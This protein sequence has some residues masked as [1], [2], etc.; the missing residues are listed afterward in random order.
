MQNTKLEEVGQIGGAYYFQKHTTTSV[1]GRCEALIFKRKQKS[2]YS[3]STNQRKV[4]YTY[5]R[6]IKEPIYTVSKKSKQ[7]R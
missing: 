4:N 6:Q 2:F 7:Y 3:S 5:T 1:I